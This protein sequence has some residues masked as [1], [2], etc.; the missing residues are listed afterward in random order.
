[1]SLGR[2][3]MTF[4]VAVLLAVS[5]AV[6]EESKERPRKERADR[7]LLDEFNVDV[8]YAGEDVARV[9]ERMRRFLEGAP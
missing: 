2:R 6:A 8:Y 9:A 1:M 5:P 4:G 3:M 7:G